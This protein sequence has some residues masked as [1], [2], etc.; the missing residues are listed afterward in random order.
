MNCPVLLGIYDGV[1]EAETVARLGKPSRER[2]DGATKIITYEN[3]GVWFYLTK[4]TIYMLGV[5]N[6]EKGDTAAF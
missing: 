2:I 5:T 1:S 6:I 4:R 3:L